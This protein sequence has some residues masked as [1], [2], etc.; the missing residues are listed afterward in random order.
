MFF[1]SLEKNIVEGFNRC[2]VLVNQ[3]NANIASS[4][5]VEYRR[6]KGIFLCKERTDGKRKRIYSRRLNA[7]IHNNNNDNINFNRWIGLNRRK[8]FR[9]ACFFLLYSIS[10]WLKTE[11][12]GLRLSFSL[13]YTFGFIYDHW[14]ISIV[15]FAYYYYKTTMLRSSKCIHKVSFS[16]YFLQS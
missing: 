13:S 15:D 14:I 2:Y 5:R 16:F 6:E 8:L 9:P 1:L 12:F 7:R 10:Y 4:I 3:T 11:A